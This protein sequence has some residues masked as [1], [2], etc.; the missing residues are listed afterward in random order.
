[1]YRQTTRSA[2]LH[3]SL[4]YAG[5]TTRRSD[6]WISAC[7]HLP[8]PS[9]YS[10]L[11][12]A[13]RAIT[14]STLSPSE[15]HEP[16]CYHR[17]LMNHFPLID[18]L[19]QYNSTQWPTIWTMLVPICSPPVATPAISARVKGWREWATHRQK[20]VTKY[21]TG[22]T[23]IENVNGPLWTESIDSRLPETRGPIQQFPVTLPDRRGGYS[24]SQTLLPDKIDQ[25]LGL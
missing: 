12:G 25:L 1:M 9:D 5:R 14:T 21:W 10:I 11:V 18:W 7:V 13:D 19:L 3:T 22:S 15:R 20:L 2:H 6:D 24:I 16:C 4:V 8:E 23:H 17:Q